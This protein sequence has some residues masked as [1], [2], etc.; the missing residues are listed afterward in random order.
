MSEKVKKF[1]FGLTIFIFPFFFLPITQDFFLTNK[2]YF[3]A[4]ICL[5]V[6]FFSFI[7]YLLSKKIIWQKKSAD[8]FLFIF[9]LSLIFSTIISSANKVQAV[10]E[11]NFGLLIFVSLTI[12]YFYLSRFS[13]LNFIKNSLIISGILLSLITII[14]FFQPLKNINLSENIKF[15]KNPNFTPV[16][17]KIDLAVI[18]GFF[19]LLTLSN[20]IK[21]TQDLKNKVLNFVLLTLSFISFS[22]TFYSILKPG[23]SENQIL[24]LPPFRLSWYSAVEVLK[25]P[26]TA[27]FGVGLNN[28][29]TIF[30]IVKDLSYNQSSLWQIYSF[31]YSRS[32]ILHIFTEAGLFGLISFGLIIFQV[33]KNIYKKKKL[34]EIVLFS[35]TLLIL[36]LFPPSLIS[37][38]L[39]FLVLSFIS[40]KEKEDEAEKEIKTLDVKDFPPLYLGFSIIWLTL[41]IT[42]SYLLGRSYL[43]EYYY[44]K[45]L[46][47]LVLNNAKITYDNI[48]QAV[49]FNSYIEKYRVSFSQ[50]NLLIA[51][52][53]AS[54]YTDGKNQPTEDDKQN[55]SQAVQ[56]AISEA[57]AALTLN[58]KKAA[59]WENLANIYK[60]IINIA[61]GADVW[62][63][64]AYQRAIV[65]DPQNPFYR[66]SLGGV[67]FS[68][69]NYDEAAKLFEQAVLLKPDWPNAHY[70]LAWADYQRGDYKK[71]AS[72]MENVLS[73]LNPKENKADYEKAKKELEEFKKKLSEKEEKTSKPEKPTQL[74]LPT[75]I[76][77]SQSKINLPKEASPEAR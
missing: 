18:L 43:A 48:R 24:N 16:G 29:S 59:Y 5:L 57:K 62:T 38:F 15:L 77:E 33:I 75:P 13:S 27:L 52:N 72:E 45:G 2:L 71:A 14:F 41:I 61:Q 39:F 66:L 76:P 67:Y 69:R 51:N 37:W 1:L 8:L 46:D 54:K 22:L 63:I 42:F 30:T 34:A 47:G 17:N 20:I 23:A 50:I 73:L 19:F 58:N 35:Y 10:L 3:L 65:L 56:A 9:L 7:R 6:L 21:K 53:L 44:K 49:I 68:L 12:V 64:S 25:Q 31:N 70:N 28:F 60:N 74:T 40:Q 55:F 26:I 4:F 11:P 36:F 32:T